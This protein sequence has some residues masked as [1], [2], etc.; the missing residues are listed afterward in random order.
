MQL[1]EYYARMKVVA[2]EKLSSK[3][4]NATRTST[5]GSI[6]EEEDN[7][8]PSYQVKLTVQVPASSFVRSACLPTH[9]RVSKKRVCCKTEGS[10]RLRHSSHKR[11]ASIRSTVKKK[12]LDAHTA[13]KD[14]DML[15]IRSDCGA[16]F[17]SAFRSRESSISTREFSQPEMP[18]PSPNEKT[19][20]F[21]PTRLP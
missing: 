1:N 4:S 8:T 15:C 12:S 13:I 20:F 9:V 10:D 3:T 5:R 11:T 2:I 18:S 14:Q 6:R 16:C 7:K 17:L 19:C 21:G